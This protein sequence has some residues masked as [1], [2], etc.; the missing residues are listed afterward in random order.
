MNQLFRRS[1]APA[2]LALLL[3]CSPAFSGLTRKHKAAPPPPEPVTAHASAQLADKKL[4]AR[5]DALLAQMTLDEK[6]GQLAQYTG[7]STITGPT[8]QKLDF[9]AMIAKGEIGS[10][11]N[12]TGAKETNHYQHIAVEQSRL[13]IPLLFGLDVI[14]GHRTTFPVPLALAAS[15]DPDIV[16]QACRVAATEARQDGI[17]WVF[18]PMVD[19]SRDARWGR[20]VESAGEDPYLGSAIA[21]AYIRGYQQGDLS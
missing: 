21:R 3:C 19:I 16:Q 20:I 17:N 9:D 14:H 2:A 12:V 10:L 5:V 4:N 8:G 1:I 18:S 11:F 7:G 15:F 13:H 6:I